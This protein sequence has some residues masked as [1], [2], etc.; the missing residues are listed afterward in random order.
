[1]RVS[2]PSP[3]SGIIGRLTAIERGHKDGI[4]KLI[5]KKLENGKI[6]QKGKYKD[7]IYDGQ[8]IWY[9]ETGA[10][11]AKEFYRKGKLE[12]TI[13]EYDEAGN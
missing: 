13:V 9:Y 6:Q 5:I 1:M 11:C 7:G 10:V 8:W 2:F 12:G 3:E 4:T